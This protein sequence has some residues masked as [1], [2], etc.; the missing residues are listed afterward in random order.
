MN[1]SKA[2]RSSARYVA[3]RK[4]RS[5]QQVM[6]VLKIGK[7]NSLEVS[8]FHWPMSRMVMILMYIVMVTGIHTIYISLVKKYASSWMRRSFTWND[9]QKSSLQGRSSASSVI[10]YS[11]KS[12]TTGANSAGIELAGDVHTSWE[13]LRTSRRKAWP[14]VNY[15]CLRSSEC[16]KWATPVG[17]AIQNFSFEPPTNKARTKYSTIAKKQRTLTSN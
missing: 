14:L 4:K 6:V 5:Q 10:K 15:L 2:R 7:T 8:S 12:I 11:R 1:F 3:Q 16:A 17:S 9:L 13:L